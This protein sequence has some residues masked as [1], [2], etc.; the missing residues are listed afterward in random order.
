SLAK[1]GEPSNDLRSPVTKHNNNPSLEPL[2]KKQRKLVTK[3]PGSIVAVEN[4]AKLAINECK[5]QF[6]NRR[7]NCPTHFDGHGSSIFGKILQK[8]CRETAFIYAITSAAV[9]HS[10]AR[11]CSEGGVTTCTCDTEPHGR[12][13]GRDWEWSGCS[14]NAKFGHR[15]SRKFVD[16]LEKGRDFRFM[17]NL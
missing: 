15:F 1:S 14:D 11:A 17:T 6:K 3:N 8:G 10:V 13:T 16:V 12:P 4:G 7:W 2:T 5:F 9:S